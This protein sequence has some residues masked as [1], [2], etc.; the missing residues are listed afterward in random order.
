MIRVF[1]ANTAFTIAFVLTAAT[2]HAQAPT[3]LTPS[4]AP[5]GVQRTAPQATAGETPQLTPE[6]VETLAQPSGVSSIVTAPKSDF[7]V[8][9]S[10]RRSIQ[11]KGLSEIDPNSVGSISI[12][13]GGLG[14]D[15]WRG[16]PRILIERLLPRLPVA[17]RSPVLR[18]LQ[19]R[20]LLTAAAMPPPSEGN[21]EASAPSLISTRIAVLQKMGAF[22]D[23]RK[24]TALTPKRTTDPEL[25]RLQAQDRLFANDYGSACQIVNTVGESLTKP[26]WQ[27]LLVFCQTLQ[28]DTQGA[29]F[30]AELLA[31]S[32]SI[33]DP[34]FFELIDRL[35]TS[36]DAPINSLPNPNPLHLAALRT[37]QISIPDNAITT[38][39]PAVLRTI[40]VSPNAQ[41]KTRLQAAELAVEF[42]AMSSSRLAEI[43]MAEK[44]DTDELNNTLSLA[45]T[46]RSPRGRALLYQAAHI[47]S[48][49]ISRA[50]VLEKAL[51]IAS[52]E[53]RYLQVIDVY[54]T[55]LANLAASSEL[56]WFASKAARALYALDRPLPAR[57]WLSELRKASTTNPQLASTIASLWLMG[58][59]TD[60]SVSAEDFDKNLM[61]WIDYHKSR[62]E[63]NWSIKTAAG[64]QLLESLGYII[65]DKAW[66]Q[67]F[68]ISNPTEVQ[69]R[70]PSLRAAI[71]R[72]AASGR[73]AETLLLILLRFGEMGPDIMDIDAV[74]DAV[75]ALKTI[76]LHTE[77]NRL[78]LEFAATAGL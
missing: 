72:A 25:L 50:A 7:S 63:K 37:A 29:A 58:L 68:E 18:D 26:Y 57:N 60:S 21:T 2:A 11:I 39:T 75:V 6:R 22:K 24:L 14:E 28:G 65:P 32:R 16:T 8:D 30:G 69:R 78:V 27:Q 40:G 55:P 41:L 33:K 54:R 36:S 73:R 61:K 12:E 70:H 67:V 49:T 19:K 31:E 38:T 10:N 15:M 23:A 62:N 59:L 56:V 77:A 71:D 42:G 76:G 43:Y 9:T 66:W 34:V 3:R 53:N 20:L 51:E 45:G 74:A 52:N 64:L 1:P 4:A 35:T 47:E 13:N 17:I 48:S 46:D 5:A 44:F